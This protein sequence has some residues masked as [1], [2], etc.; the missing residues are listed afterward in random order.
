MAQEMKQDSNFKVLPKEFVT[1]EIILGR[2]KEKFSN[3]TLDINN[4]QMALLSPELYIVVFDNNT[5][6]PKGEIFLVPIQNTIRLNLFPST[7]NPIIISPGDI[8]RLQDVGKTRYEQCLKA[9]GVNNLPW[10]RIIN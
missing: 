2:I 7:S 3:S 4:C 1:R 6:S 5:C 9:Q 8:S 10:N